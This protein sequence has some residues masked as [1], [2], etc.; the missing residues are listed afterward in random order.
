MYLRDF[1]QRFKDE[2]LTSET[3]SHPD[4]ALLSLYTL[5]DLRNITVNGGVIK[6]KESFAKQVQLHKL[7]KMGLLLPSEITKTLHEASLTKR[8]RGIKI[9]DCFCYINEEEETQSTFVQMDL[10]DGTT[11]VV[12]SGTDDTIVGW[13]ENYNLAY[14]ECVPC[15]KYALEYV[16]NLKPDRKYIFI[17]HSKGGMESLYAGLMC[18]KEIQDCIISINDYDGTG[19]QQ[20]IY[21]QLKDSPYLYKANLVVPNA[22]TVGRIFFHPIEPKIVYSYK[23]GLM[24]HNPLTWRIKDKEFDYVNDFVPGSE[25][26]PKNISST[27]NRFS[28][29]DLK[30]FEIALFDTLGAGGAKTL[31]DIIP[32][33]FDVE[34]AFIKLSMKN[35]KLYL[36]FMRHLINGKL[37]SVEMLK[38]RK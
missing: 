22:S 7:K 24:Q 36:R 14:G 8:Y 30:E 25:T 12:F 4:G 15:L 27:P 33:L 38:L 19:Y 32:K 10:K 9:H 18:K 13:K 16:N 34:K 5:A 28:V 2:V 21:D 23:L 6:F 35:K 26:F 11:V 17:G 31:T 20:K 37:I 3:F 1:V 29:E